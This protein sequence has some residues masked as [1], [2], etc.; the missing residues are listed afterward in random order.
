MTSL[1]KEF[2]AWFDQFMTDP[3]SF[4]NRDVRVTNSIQSAVAVAGAVH[5]DVVNIL[6]FGE[7]D[8]LATVPCYGTV[9]TD[10]ENGRRGRSFRRALEDRHAGHFPHQSA[11]C[12]Y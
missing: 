8:R 7:G 3:G 4:R 9:S 12:G 2:C 6:P 5:S 11:T 10:F 1:S